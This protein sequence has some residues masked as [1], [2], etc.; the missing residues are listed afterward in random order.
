MK[1]FHTILLDDLLSEKLYYFRIISSDPIGNQSISND[2]T[3]TTLKAS[4]DESQ[5]EE[6]ELA[7][8]LEKKGEA[9]KG[10]GEGLG[11]GEY[12]KSELIMSML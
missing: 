5:E 1:K 10:E 7:E 2:Y 3:F 8:D 11:E 4:A 12:E 9:G 6:G